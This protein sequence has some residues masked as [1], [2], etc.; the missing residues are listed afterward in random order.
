M[1]TSGQVTI[2]PPD[3][4]LPLL[5]L[6]RTLADNPLK[7]WPRAFYRERCFRWR[8]LRRDTLFVMAPDLIREVFVHQVDNF[9]KGEIP[10]RMLVPLFGDS[11]GTAHGPRWRWQHRA[12]AP[13]FRQ[14][15]IRK[16]VPAMLAAAERTRDRWRAHPSGVEIDV[17]REMM[18]T[19]FDIIFNTLFSE[20]YSIDCDLIEQ[21]ISTYTESL[22]WIFAL[23]MLGAPSWVPYPGVR[24][25]RR[26]LKDLYRLLDSLIVE[27]KRCPFNADDLPSVLTHATD[28]ETGKPMNDQ[29]VRYNLLTFM[30]AGYETTAL[31]LTW[32]FYL[33]SLHPEIEQRVKKETTDA[34]RGG[35]LG[36][37]HIEALSYT[38]RVI[39]ES[40]RLYPPVPTLMRTAGQD[41]HLGNEKVRKGTLVVVPVY[42]LHRH[43]AFWPRPDE[44]DPNRFEPE[45]AKGRDRYSYLP[46]GAGPHTCIGQA[47]GQLAAAAVLA[48]LLNSFQLRLRSGY[49]PEPR[50]RLTLRPAGGMPMRIERTSAQ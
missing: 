22:S 16:F 43:V 47:F 46:F 9:E 49:I 42:A 8:G 34:T 7:A 32:T 4:P 45:R 19:T 5:S 37:E 21:S 10:L 6:L 35:P 29:D 18:R 36:A 41:T 38:T 30:A 3:Q 33:L 28:P 48:T 12:A 20:P 13:F 39:Q 31:A 25:A 2:E 11:I 44:F 23:A 27:T 14:D 1:S 50:L 26:A 15:Q 40:M 24:K 17:G